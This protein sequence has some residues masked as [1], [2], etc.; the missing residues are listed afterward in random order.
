MSTVDRTDTSVIGNW[1]WTVDRWSLGALALLVMFGAMMVFAAS[2][3]VAERLNLGSYHFVQRQLMLL[4]VAVM[5]MLAISLADPLVI[6]RL[7]CLGFAGCIVLLILT[8]VFGAEIKGAQRWL[9]I[10]GFSLQASEFV[11]PCFAV[12]TAWMFAEWRRA[13]G[14]PGHWIA[15]GLYALV[16]GL[17]LLQPDLGQTVIVSAVWF[18]QFV[19]AGL[20]VILVFSLVVIGVVGL[21]GAY[22]TFGHV[23][24]RVDRFLDPAG[25]DTYQVDR[26]L[27][28]F[29]NG[30]LM[31]TGPG[32]GEIKTFL[33][34][35][36][37]DFVF[38][39]AGEEFGALVG[40][41]I[42]AVFGFLVLR[43][44]LRLISESNLFVLIA[45]AGLLAQLG[46]QSF[47]HM[48]SSL[49]LIPAKGMT[50]PFISYGGSSLLAL[51]LGM[52]MMLAL[53]R[54]RPGRGGMS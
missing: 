54:K 36:H 35:A 23:S 21:V 45:A 1:W 19:L 26:S 43:G 42:I 47:V 5:S 6:R 40:L 53:T 22:F 13:P 30:G 48:A 4:P 2:P 9:S 11:K 52:G 10:A 37:A 18:G 3:A 50:L 27:E 49:Q 33:P 29:A 7:A 17:L 24:D 25:S 32:E 34:D 31:G 41:V 12:V 15:I 38:A 46:L 39:V 8:L 14:F 20:P 44:Y 16:A 28:A 51:S